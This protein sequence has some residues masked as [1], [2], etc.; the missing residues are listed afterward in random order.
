MDFFKQTVKRRKTLIDINLIRH[1]ETSLIDEKLSRRGGDYKIDQLCDLDRKRLELQKGVETLRKERNEKSKE[2]GIAKKRGDSADDIMQEVRAIGEKLK[3]YEGELATLETQ[4]KAIILMVPNIPDDSIPDGKS[5]EDNLEI[6]RVGEPKNFDF[7]IRP[8]HE[9]GE[10]LGILDM[11][12]AAKL[13]GARFA[14]LKGAGALMERALI[15]FM[16]DLHT[17]KHGYT[18]VLPPVMVNSATMQG[19][20]QLPK[21]AEDL[22]KIEKS[23]YWLIPTAEVPVTNIHAG[24]ILDGEKLPIRMTA[25][26]PCFRAEA[27]SYG[28]DTTGLIR[29]HQFNKVELVE[30][31]K[32]EESAKALEELLKHAEEVLRLL[33]LPYRVLTLCAGDIGF[34]SAKTY[35]IEVWVPSQNKYREISSCSMFTDFQARRMNMRMRRE[36]GAKPEFVHTINGSG[37]AVGRTLVAILENYQNAD[38]TITVPPALRSYMGGLEKIEPVA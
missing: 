38:G 32:P 14:L 11:K 10:A 12:R 4:I 9:L 20:G 6:K 22:F 31:V 18:E 30:L 19:T 7:E 16:L 23:D 34:S 1:K 35:D 15:N 13:S 24:E 2:V 25:Y 8:H 28:K 36:K 5:E 3:L 26:T 33:E 21:F 27:G 37:L 17:K 29:Q